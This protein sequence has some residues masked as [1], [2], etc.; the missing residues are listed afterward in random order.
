VKSD[1]DKAPS[2][3]AHDHFFT[4]TNAYPNETLDTVELAGE[5]L[6]RIGL[7][8]VARLLALNGSVKVAR[9]TGTDQ[10]T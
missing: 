3:W 10:P 8:L 7:A 2:A 5:Q 4:F 1:R 6:E 9:E